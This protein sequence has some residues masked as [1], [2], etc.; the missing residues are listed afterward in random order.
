ME[1]RVLKSYLHTHIH[2]SIINSQEVETT[3]KSISEEKDKQIRFIQTYSGI[4]SSLKKE[5]NSATC[6]NMNATWGHYAKWNKPVRKQQIRY[7]STYVGQLKQSNPQ[8]QRA[9]LRFAKGLEAWRA[10]VHGVAMSQTALRDWTEGA[11]GV[12]RR[13]TF[14]Q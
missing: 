12:R 11:G 7:D 10:A 14:Y 1:S 9:E 3:P 13:G 6:Y 8:R 4:L 2:S 5:G